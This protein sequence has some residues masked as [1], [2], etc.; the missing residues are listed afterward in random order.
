MLLAEVALA[1]ESRD[2]VTQCTPRIR[3]CLILVALDDIGYVV[4]GE[5]GFEILSRVGECLLH[6]FHCF[7]SCLSE[8]LQLL[9][10]LNLRLLRPIRGLGQILL[11]FIIVLRD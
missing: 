9:V 10:N 7:F 6:L 1:L 3:L 8:L 5:D 4:S 11:F 2:E